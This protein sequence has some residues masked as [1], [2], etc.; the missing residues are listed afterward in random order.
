MGGFKLWLNDF[1]VGASNISSD[2]GKVDNENGTHS[3][4]HDELGVKAC[5]LDLCQPLMTKTGNGLGWELN[6]TLCPDDIPIK[7][8]GTQNAYALFFRND[9]IEPDPDINYG[10]NTP[11][12]NLMVV[13]PLTGYNST[14]SSY[15]NKHSF[16]NAPFLR[17]HLISNNNVC[18]GLNDICISMTYTLN[19][20]WGITRSIQDEGFYPNNSSPIMFLHYVD[21]NSS[22]LGTSE[23]KQFVSLVNYGTSD[24]GYSSS[25]VNAYGP[26]PG[27]KCRYFIMA[28]EFGDVG[29]GASYKDKRPYM[30]FIGDFYNKKLNS[31]DN[32][33]TSKGGFIQTNISDATYG[34]WYYGSNATTTTSYSSNSI[35]TNFQDFN[36]DGTWLN[37]MTSSGS[38][39]NY[40][41]CY[42]TNPSLRKYTA[43][44]KTAHQII[45]NVG[46]LDK[47]KIRAIDRTGAAIGQTY[48]S[49]QWC[50]I[51]IPDGNIDYNFSPMRVYTSNDSSPSYFG[52]VI[53]WDGEYNGDKTFY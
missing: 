42:I 41:K 21:T 1:V 8:I 25:T 5:L 27:T 53:H 48:N 44:Y 23:A 20:C 3:Y 15:V 30:V 11:G 47:Q 33:V 18:A 29:I 31:G 22:Y 38:N 12:R 37:A 26:V 51:S 28:N 16:L 49:K 14:E 24:T 7:L 40:R 13:L 19:D 43:Q 6:R 4:T 36:T 50:F 39:S 9:E 52:A 35:Y 2:T 34:I 45:S 10:N 32:L 46:F 17:T